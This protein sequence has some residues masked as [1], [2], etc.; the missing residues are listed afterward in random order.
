VP[1]DKK[2]LLVNIDYRLCMEVITQIY[3]AGYKNLNLVPYYGDESSRDKSI[4]T[5]ITPNE[6]KIVPPGIK[7]VINIGD[8]VLDINSVIDLA[9]ELGIYKIFNT[10][11][12]QKARKDLLLTSNGIEKLLGDNENLFEQ[13][14]VLIELMEDG[15]VLT[16]LMNNIY[17]ANHKAKHMLI[18]KSKNIENSDISEILPELKIDIAM[19]S[20]KQGVSEK[21][22]SIDDANIIARFSTIYSDG[23]SKGNI[24]TLRNFDEI[25][26]KQHIIRTKI[27]GI[28]HEAKY[29]LKTL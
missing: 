22:I 29:K 11:E 16:D 7:D 13:I 6:M 14:K 15:I 3:E 19:D 1:T 2:I 12:A 4:V 26:E 18:K 25:E 5:A 10:I 21:I 20:K 27:S 23:V 24:I 9:A 8:R 17:L 28:R